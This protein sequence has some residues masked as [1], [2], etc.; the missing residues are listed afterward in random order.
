MYTVRPYN[1]KPIGGCDKSDNIAT[2]GGLLMPMLGYK[3]MVDEHTQ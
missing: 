2:P 3:G 1:L